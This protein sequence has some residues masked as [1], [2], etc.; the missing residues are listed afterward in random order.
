MISIFGLRPPELVP[1]FENPEA[2]FWLTIIDDVVVNEDVM[3]EGLNSDLRQCRWIDCL[4]R[5]VYLRLNGLSEVMTLVE[6]N[7]ADLPTAHYLTGE[8]DRKRFAIS[9]N[10]MVRDLIRAHCSQAR[11]IQVDA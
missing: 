6:E 4:G 2:Y 7:L 1:V 9:V 11:T 5:R 3:K 8:P 10:E